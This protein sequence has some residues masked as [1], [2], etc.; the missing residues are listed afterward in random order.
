MKFF[1]FFVKQVC[2]LFRFNNKVVLFESSLFRNYTGNPRYIY[3][4][5]V[6]QGL[7]EKFDIYWIAKDPSTLNTDLMPGH[8]NVCKYKTFQ[9]YKLFSSAAFIIS[10]SRL[11]KYLYKNKK[12]KYIQTWHGTPLKKLALDMKTLDMGGSNDIKTYH[13]NF[14][15]SSSMWDY[16]ISQ[17]AF[18]TETFKRCFAYDGEFLEIGYPRNDKLINTTPSDI[19]ALKRDMGLPLNKKIILYAP[20]WRDNQF[21]KQGEY[22]FANQVDFDALRDALSDEYVMIVKYHYLIKDSVDWSQYEGFVYQYGEEYDIA[23]L[24]LVSDMLITDYSSVMFDYSV[25]NRPLIFFTYDL[26][27]YMNDLRGFYFDLTK[28]APGPIVKTNEELID[29][30]V[31][32]NEADWDQRYKAFHNK[33]NSLDDGTASRKV[34]DLIKEQSKID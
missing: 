33:Y 21:Y 34:V 11:P 25:L 6:A 24:Y 14:K 23:N 9:F 28:E 22:K 12:T 27:E 32:Y 4:E 10:D 2:R 26:E 5:M 3:E 7:D 18:S 17:N 8:F 1:A 20:T 13:K 15:K 31:N 29:A 30:I 19:Y 16:F